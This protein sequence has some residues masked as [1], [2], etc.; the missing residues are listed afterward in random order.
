MRKNI[1]ERQAKI[2][3]AIVS[4]YILDG[5]PV[6][7]HVIVGKYGLAISSATVRKEMSVL[8][9]MGYILSP[10]TS[11]G[12][13]PTDD[14][15]QYYVNELVGLYRITVSEKS[16]LEA[17]YKKAKWQ[18]DQLLK[19]T[20]R[21]LSI[22]SNSAAVVLAPVSTGSIIKR[23]ELISITENL[24][25]AIVVGQSGSI[26]QKKIKVEKATNQ[27]GLY[28][29]SRYLNQ[30]LRGYEIADLQEKGLDFLVETSDLQ[31]QDL[32]NIAIKVV[33][34]FV[35]DP[36]DQ[37]VYIGGEANFYRQ[38]LENL[39]DTSSVESIMEQL[40]DHAFVRKIINHL[41]DASKVTSRIGI[42]LN[43]EYIQGISILAK[44]YSVGGRDMGALGVIGTSRIPY[45]KLIPTI[46]Y[47]SILLSNVLSERYESDEDFINDNADLKPIYLIDDVREKN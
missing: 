47:S 7:S 41:R 18:L 45:E 16:K 14:A 8:E 20:A 36:P 3:R 4:E 9:Q 27:E 10:H 35:Y 33:Q 24:V 29:I 13:I 30:Y 6:G 12:R 37:Q 34:S 17:F 40:F 5:Q 23:I 31:D 43:D 22:T 15:V 1:T 38:L 39:S 28:K 25:L 44:G 26:F 21:L 42:E 19:R 11:A 46:D 2:I 32:M